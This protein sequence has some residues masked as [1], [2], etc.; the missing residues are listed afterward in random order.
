MD[1][2]TKVAESELVR[3]RSVI[4][5]LSLAGAVSLDAVSGR[6]QTSPR[7]LQRRLTGLGIS[8]REVVEEARFEIACALLR[9]TDLKVQEIAARLG[10]ATPSSFTRAFG[11]WAGCS[12]SAFRRATPRDISLARNG[13]KH[14]AAPR[15]NDANQ[16]TP[17]EP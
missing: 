9:G 3:V 12:P 16:D 5:G 8:F 2:P 6:L 15:I 13:Q 1:Q 10:Y 7:T 17:K 4:A 11:R 14:I